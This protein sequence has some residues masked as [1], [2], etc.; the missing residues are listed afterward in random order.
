MS[1]CQFPKMG[2]R[3]HQLKTKTSN[4]IK[5]KKIEKDKKRRLNEWRQWWS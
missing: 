4:P 2:T 1:K 3:T 5:I